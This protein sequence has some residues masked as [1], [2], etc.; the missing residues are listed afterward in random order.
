LAKG[1][2]QLALFPELPPGVRKR[3]PKLTRAFFALWP[4]AAVRQ[5]LMRTADQIPPG[6]AGRLQRVKSDRYHLTLAFLGNIEARQIEAAERA[7]GAVCAP[8]FVL[9]LDS[10]GHFAGPNVV[11]IGP[12][13]ICRELAQLKTELDR[14]LLRF[15]LPVA[16]GAF[17]PHISCL[18]GVRAAPDAAA[19]QIDWPVTEFVLVKT[20]VKDGVSQYKI[21]GRW[22]LASPASD[23]AER[24]L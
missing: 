20:V 8:A 6:D 21:A 22:P 4:D 5:A 2:S 13:T 3:P 15:G 9:R 14:E 17:A 7:A 10:I 1:E 24:R 11:W 16:A 19:I 12:G 23:D 18:R